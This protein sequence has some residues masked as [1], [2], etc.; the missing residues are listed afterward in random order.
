MGSRGIASYNEP[1]SEPPARGSL[2]TG[3]VKRF[4]GALRDAMA[5]EE[6]VSGLAL[7][8]CTGA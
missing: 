7:G 5:T 3:F 4:R 8:K 2:S 6:D 1:L